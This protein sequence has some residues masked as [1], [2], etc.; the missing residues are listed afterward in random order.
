MVTNIVKNR[1]FIVLNE[2]CMKVV[3]SVIYI[4]GIEY[5]FP[6]ND[7]WLGINHLKD[8][9]RLLEVYTLFLAL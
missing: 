2:Q 8:K 3:L 9:K 6:K 4:E 5:F 1:T 7:D